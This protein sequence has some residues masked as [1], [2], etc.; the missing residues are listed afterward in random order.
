MFVLLLVLVPSFRSSATTVAAPSASP[1]GTFSP[2]TQG[3][4]EVASLATQNSSTVA[5]NGHY[6]TTVSTHSLNYRGGTGWQ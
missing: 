3:N 5:Q 6:V 1:P 4:G 2:Q